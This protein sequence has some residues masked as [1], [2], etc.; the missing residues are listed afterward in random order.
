MAR[1]F[2]FAI[3]LIGMLLNSPADAV[4]YA[5]CQDQ[6]ANCIGRCAN[7]LGG[8]NQSPCMN[9]CDRQATSCAVRAY[10]ATRRWWR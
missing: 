5:R 7:P 9:S 6:S 3:P 2:F 10:D 1:H 8:A 4:T